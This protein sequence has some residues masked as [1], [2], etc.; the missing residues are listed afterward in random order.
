VV[1]TIVASLKTSFNHQIKTEST[2][3]VAWV[4]GLP[5]LTATVSTLGIQATGN[6]C[7]K[8]QPRSLRTCLKSAEKE[9]KK[10]L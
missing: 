7:T 9:K 4:P 6:V 2:G 3:N 5:R 10:Q 8:G 1:E